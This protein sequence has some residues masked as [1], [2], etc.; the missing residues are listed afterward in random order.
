[1]LDRKTEAK[2][3]KDT[4]RALGIV[5]IRNTANG[6]CLIEAS[7]D[8]H[9]LINR[10]QFM[11]KMGSHRNAELVRDWGEYG[12]EAFRFEVLDTLDPS[13]RPDYDPSD[14]LSALA[15]LWID[16]LQPFGDKGYNVV[17]RRS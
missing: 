6:R 9:S 16:K 1:M 17:K 11:L 12:A 13:D 14:D 5:C 15:D 10:H 2:K 7:R 8:V 4:P 3:Y